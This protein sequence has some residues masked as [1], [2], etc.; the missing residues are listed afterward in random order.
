[1][2]GLIDAG[3]SIPV[4]EASLP[5]IERINGGHIAQYAEVLKKD[6]EKYN[7]HFSSLLKDGWVP[8]NYPNYFEEVKTRIIR[9]M[10]TVPHSTVSKRF[11][12]P[13]RNAPV[14]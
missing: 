9:N 10:K 8:E 13:T 14:I 7:S 12:S 3:V 6:E 1:L 5:K 11:K 4:S 2:K